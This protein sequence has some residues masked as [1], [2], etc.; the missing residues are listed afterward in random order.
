MNNAAIAPEST[1]WEN[2]TN[3][4]ATF[5]VN[6]FGYVAQQFSKSRCDGYVI[7]SRE[8]A[9]DIHPGMVPV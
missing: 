8:R 9:T 4:K 6:L 2:L 1:S 3:W 5:D 7:Q